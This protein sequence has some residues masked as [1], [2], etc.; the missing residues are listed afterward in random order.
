M[1]IELPK[2]DDRAFRDIADEAIGR[3]PS[4]TPEWTNFNEADPGVTLLELFAFMAENML[5]RANQIPER[6]RLKF[7]QL[8]G[9]PLLPAQPARGVVAFEN[10]RGPLATLTLNRGEPLRAGSL[11]FRTTQG[12]DVL[13]VESALVFKRTLASPDAVTVSYTHLRAHE[14]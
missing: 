13:P 12:L 6:N 8:L 14:T 9:V 11:P 4:H 1:P 2:L 10:A 5:Y 7:L 3:I